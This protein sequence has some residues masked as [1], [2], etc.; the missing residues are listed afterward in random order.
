[1]IIED[2]ILISFMII[3]YDQIRHLRSASDGIWSQWLHMAPASSAAPSVCPS[4]TAQWLS[5]WT[6]RSRWGVCAKM[7][8]SARNIELSITAVQTE[9]LVDAVCRNFVEGVLWT[10]F[11]PHSRHVHTTCIPH[12]YYIYL[13]HIYTTFISRL[14]CTPRWFGM[15][16]LENKS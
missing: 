10:V 13:H 16:V 5:I 11:I 6:R 8:A 3:W 9:N 2:I 7:A 14:Y 12:S 4:L 1:M 15:S